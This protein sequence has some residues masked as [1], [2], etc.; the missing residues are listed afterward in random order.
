MSKT[1][2]SL[3]QEKAMKQGYIPRYEYV[4]VKNNGIY[5]TFLYKVACK[6]LSANGT[7]YTKQEA[8]H[9]AA[10]NILL[11]LSSDQK[12]KAQMSPVLSS[13]SSITNDTTSS[14]T[15]D[16]TSSI[17]NNATCFTPN[18]YKTE[19]SLTTQSSPT[20]FNGFINYVGLLQV[21]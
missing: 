17:T 15:N 18:N 14:I 3:L 8:K 7:G 12:D 10:K 5:S 16:T 6:D 20:S 9:D 21:S 11:L 19:S 1:P 4:G 2:V 13:A